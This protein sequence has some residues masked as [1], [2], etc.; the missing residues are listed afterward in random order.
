MSWHTK[1]VGAYARTSNEAKENAVEIYN[2]LSAKGWTLNAISGVIGNIGW[3]GGY[4]PWRWQSD[5]VI[6]HLDLPSINYQSG[7]A[8]G[9]FQFDPAGSYINNTT[10]QSYSGFGPNFNDQFGSLRDGNAQVLLVSNNGTGGYIQTASY[11]LSFQQ[12]Q[13]SNATPE[14]LALA[15]FYNFERGVGHETDRQNEARYWYDLLPSIIS[16]TKKFK[17]IYYMKRRRF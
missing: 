7:H 10:A 2:I 5:D 15:W 3:E 16:K 9:L 12:Y 17:W 13:Q 6:S 14:Y 11:P 1:A 4:N 8:Y